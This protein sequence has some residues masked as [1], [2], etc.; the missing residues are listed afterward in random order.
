MPWASPVPH[1]FLNCSVCVFVSLLLVPQHDDATFALENQWPYH[2][3][4]PR[5]LGLG[6]LCFCHFSRKLEACV[7][8]PSTHYFNSRGFAGQGC[9]GYEDGVVTGDRYSGREGCRRGLCP[10][11]RACPAGGRVAPR[12]AVPLGSGKQSR[13]GRGLASIPSCREARVCFVT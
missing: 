10:A 9:P 6:I 3:S 7:R 1:C 13:A 5:P 2:L 4:S 12:P 11:M 8:M